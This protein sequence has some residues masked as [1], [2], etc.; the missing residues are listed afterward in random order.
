M[1]SNSRITLKGQ[2]GKGGFSHIYKCLDGDG[3]EKAVKCLT[4]NQKTGITCLFECVIMSKLSFPYLNSCLSIGFTLNKLYL[5]QELA[6]C[7]L[8][9]WRKKNSSSEFQSDEQMKTWISQVLLAIQHL[10]SLNI[11]HGD[12]KASNILLY[13]TGSIKLTD[14][15]LSF[16]EDW[17]TDKCASSR[18]VCTG[19]H[20]PLEVWLGK[21]WNRSV[22]VWAFGCFIYELTYGTQLFPNT[23]PFQDRI[24]L[25]KKWES[26]LNSEKND[27]NLF[28][29]FNNIQKIPVNNLLLSILQVD[30]SKRFTLEE[31]QNHEYLSTCTF[32]DF[33]K[34][35][36]EVLNPEKIVKPIGIPINLPENVKINISKLYRQVSDLKDITN[37]NKLKT[38][39]HMYK[40][41]ISGETQ[42][43]NNTSTSSY[44]NTFTSLD[45]ETK[46]VKYERHILKY[47]SFDIPI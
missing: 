9:E 2:I 20:R 7:D 38:C 31:I 42:L 27:N 10:H 23:I 25:F 41:M 13:S 19:S 17:I 15:S 4:I 8:F 6:I 32:P 26:F 43:N 35:N 33:G 22:D 24:E 39:I 3:A 34:I 1:F 46:L 11:V 37:L 40:K 44:I 45:E 28:K 5:I 29:N 12:I 18:Q 21:K 47:V 30:V 16:K 36:P 14:Y